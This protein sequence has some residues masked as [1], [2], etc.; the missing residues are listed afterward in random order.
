MLPG[1]EETLRITLELEPA[2]D[3]IAGRLYAHERPEHSF[4]GWLEFAAAL[5][6]ACKEG[7][8]LPGRGGAG[9]RS[10]HEA[11]GSC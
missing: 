10:E 9:A 5:E 11:P 1:V 2:A 3:P 6:A 8:A 7:S 4:F